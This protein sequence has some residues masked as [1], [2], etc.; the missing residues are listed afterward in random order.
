MPADKPKEVLWHFWVHEAD[1]W[2]L[3]PFLHYSNCISH[4]LLMVNLK[5][6]SKLSSATGEVRNQAPLSQQPCHIIWISA[7][8]L[9]PWHVNSLQ[10]LSL[11]WM[12]DHKYLCSHLNAIK[13]MAA[14]NSND[15]VHLPGGL[16]FHTPPLFYNSSVINLMYSREH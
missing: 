11:L 2:G 16:C 3:H 15:V 10:H 9:V 1:R 4:P 7:P 12:V 5:A 8:N 14:L 13:Q 6:H